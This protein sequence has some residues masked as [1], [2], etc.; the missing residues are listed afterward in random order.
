MFKIFFVLFTIF[1]NF[2]FG[3]R[4]PSSRITLTEASE[5]SQLYNEFVARDQMIQ[6]HIRSLSPSVKRDPVAPN[7]TYTMILEYNSDDN[8]NST[9]LICSQTEYYFDNGAT[10]SA[11]YDIQTGSLMQKTDGFVP[12]GSNMVLYWYLGTAD[13]TDMFPK[14][15]N[16]TINFGNGTQVYDAATGMLFYFGFTPSDMGLPLEYNGTMTIHSFSFALQKKQ[17]KN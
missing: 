11:G 1:C 12:S 10:L 15:V 17:F 13:N 4:D 16:T 6:T 7:S 8:Y 5:G 9:G 14:A 3:L 2:S